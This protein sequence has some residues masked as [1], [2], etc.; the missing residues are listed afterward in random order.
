VSPDLEL[1]RHLVDAAGQ[2]THER[3]RDWVS[4]L[5]RIVAGLAARWGLTVGRPFQPGGQTAWVAPVRDAA[6]RDLV[7]K[8]GW[9]N[10]ESRHEADGLRLWAGNGTVLLYADHVDGDTSALLLERARPGT[11]LGQSLPEEEQ[12]VVVAEVFDRLWLRPPAGHPFRPLADMCEQWAQEHEQDPNTVLDPGV[13]RAGLELW[14]SLPDTADREV[15]LLTDLHGGNVLAAEREPWLV[16]DPKPYVGDPAYDPLQH[17][18]NC[19]DRLHADPRGLADRMADLCEVDPERF[20][21][22]LFARC[23]VESPWWPELAPVAS[24]LARMA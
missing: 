6:G 3:R 17:L 8:A 1:P 23:A 18:L 7:L 11:E 13:A 24:A 9:T 5:P 21:L 20:R 22:W 14:R 4:R 15:L 10:D 12:D 2:D 16:I 19:P